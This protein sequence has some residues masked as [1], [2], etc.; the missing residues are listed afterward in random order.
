MRITLLT[1]RDS[2]SHL[3]LSQLV[4]QLA[5]HEISI[6]IS[7]K[8][9][10]DYLLP[11]PLMALQSFELEL[12]QD[13]RPSFEQLAVKAGGSLQGFVDIDNKVNGSAGLERIKATRPDLIISVRFGLIIGQDIIDIPRY[14]VI[15]LHSGVLPSYR[16]VMATLRAMLNG[17]SDIGS[18]LHFIQD[19][20]IDTGDII[21]VA[22]L[23]LERQSSYLLNVLSLYSGGVKQIMDAVK[24]LSESNTLQS[25]S[26][27]GIP[28]YFTFPTTAE[29]N[30]FS[31][32]G[33]MLFDPQ[34]RTAITRLYALN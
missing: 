23:P 4:R 27:Q 6:F 5:D 9:G 22:T 25:H 17:D 15:N 33:Y 34:E 16:G 8:V 26:Q 2:P 20:G 30:H 24:T 14:G 29:L 13:G 7:E 10:S 11:S 3:A 28:R 1:N 21:S 32:Q 12:L 19:S 18:T 31:T